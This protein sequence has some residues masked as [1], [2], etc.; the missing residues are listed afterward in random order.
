MELGIAN[1]K[2]SDLFHWVN[3]IGM[4]LVNVDTKTGTITEGKR[5]NEKQTIF[6]PL[7]STPSYVYDDN[8]VGGTIIDISY[9]GKE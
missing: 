9:G 5:T 1:E 7:Y 4:G 6:V 8:D 2:V 3:A